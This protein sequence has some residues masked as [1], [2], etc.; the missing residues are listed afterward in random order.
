MRIRIYF[1]LSL[2]IT[3]PFLQ[4]SLKA[5]ENSFYQSEI[6]DSNKIDIISDDSLDKNFDEDSDIFEAQLS[7][8]K[9]IFSEAIISDLTGDTL[10]A[11]Y[12]FDLLFESLAE[13]D[14]ISRTGID[15]F[16][17]LEL[18]RILTAV[19][20]YYENELIT[21]DKVET[22]L[23]V[24]IFRDK[25]NKYI[26]S[27]RLEDIEF[28]EEKVELIPGSVPITYNQ[29]VASIIK[30]FQNQ[31]RKSIQN[32][33]NRMDRYKKI[34]LP[35]L[36]EM[37]VPSELFYL[38]MIESG[39]NPNAY[40]YAHAAGPWQFI[41]STG[42]IYDLKIDWWVDERRDFI[43]STYA[44][45]KYLKDLHNRFGDWYLAFAAYNCG[46]SRVLKEMKRS[47]STNFWDLNR[48]PG[49]T[50]N[51]VPKI[52][53]FFLISKNPEKY[54]FNIINEPNL[55][56]VN[57]KID[58]QISFQQISDITKIDIKTLQLYNPEIKRGILPPIDEKSYYDLRLPKM[59]NYESFDS[60]YNLLKE[61]KTEDFMVVEYVVKKG[62]NLSRI[63]S[64]YRIKIQDITSMNKI[65]DKKYL[66]PGQILQIPMQG[67][68]EYMQ[69]ILSSNKTK[70]IQYE[71]KS[72]DTISELA[73][74][75][76]T[77]QKKIKSWNGIR[78]D[79]I[80]IGK[81]LIIYVPINFDESKYTKKTTRKKTYTV[82]RGDSLSRIGHKYKV[83]VN[84]IKS[85][86]DLKSNTIRPGQKLIIYTKH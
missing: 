16:Q 17:N 66:Q 27:Q 43:K 73:E 86:N 23:S 20:D 1:I 29:K 79:Q 65:S 4:D 42:K 69:T 6:L 70:K 28:V 31:G 8:I 11:I 80:Y 38:A 18:N 39:L 78:N 48:L 36:E 15:E 64:K 25:L 56:W 77:S 21:I 50:R 35:I 24:A 30:F 32:W 72:G 51:Y 22:G 37:E 9:M 62:D 55:D 84:K 54:G 26:Y 3:I 61:K 46:A 47:N 45:A 58:K 81:K 85:W 74:R 7:E 19:I 5:I 59:A 76:R 68:D 53:A 41:A 10:E 63:A 34:M 57:K 83:S 12:Q 49:Q 13:L 2:F 75:F 40:S 14:M 71:V 60:L 52:L 44:A 67:Y 33:L 82:K